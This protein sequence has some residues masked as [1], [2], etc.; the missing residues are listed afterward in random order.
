MQ[1]NKKMTNPK[2]AVTSEKGCYKFCIIN[3][4]FMQILSMKECGEQNQVFTLALVTSLS[5]GCLALKMV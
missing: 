4:Q 1:N 3:H 5:I 2:T